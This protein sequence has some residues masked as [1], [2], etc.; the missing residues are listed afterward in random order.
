MI[1]DIFKFSLQGFYQAFYQLLSGHFVTGMVRPFQKESQYNEVI[2]QADILA[3]SD[4]TGML[5]AHVCAAHNFVS[6][7]LQELAASLHECRN[8][9][10]LNHVYKC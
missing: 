10:E 1:S 9:F 4:G 5:A 6:G 3:V 8:E 7:E 2:T